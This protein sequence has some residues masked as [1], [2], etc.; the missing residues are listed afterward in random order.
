MGREKTEK[1]KKDPSRKRSRLERISWVGLVKHDTS[2]IMWDRRRIEEVK[3][4]YSKQHDQD[5]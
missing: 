3:I 2:C 1:E 4:E 5:S